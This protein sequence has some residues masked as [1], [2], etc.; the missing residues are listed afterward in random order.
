MSFYS[1]QEEIEANNKTNNMQMY[2][3]QNNDDSNNLFTNNNNNDG[4]Y[5]NEE[6]IKQEEFDNNN[7]K[8]KGGGKGDEFSTNY[9]VII[10]SFEH[11]NLSE[12]L[13]RGIFSYGWE[14]PSGIQQRAIRPMIEGRDIIA[15]AQSGTGKTGT[16]SISSLQRID[17][18]NQQCQ[19]LILSPTREIANQTF[20]VAS[21]LGIYLIDKHGLTIH[22]CIGGTSIRDDIY[23]LSSGKQIIIGTPGRV[24][25]VI[26][27]GVLN[28]KSLSL[29]ILDEADEMLSRGFKEQIY[30]C[31]QYLP[32]DVQVSLVSATMPI[33]VLKLTKRFM[34]NNAVQILVK[35][36]ELTLDG[37]K[38]YYVDTEKE[39][40][41]LATLF[42]LY[43]SLTIT[44]AIIF[45]NTR[46]KVMWLR[47]KMSQNDFTVS[48][49]HGDLTQSDRELVMKE[50]RSGTSRVLISTD[51]LSRGI[52]VQTVSLVINYDLPR[53][54]ESYIH[55]IGR[56][57]RY[58]RKGCAINFVY[59]D[60]SEKLR[61]LETFYNTIISELPAEL[62]GITN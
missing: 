58:G 23:Q 16:F 10:E 5:Q 2:D 48:F 35:N 7:K 56:S 50:F 25:H 42:D 38:Q 45:V 21:S 47:D 34:R 4:H 62:N 49:I 51:I 19:V 61:E 28:L 27:K 59:N 11:M 3:H 44:Q 18:N 26:Q 13:L 33:E 30:E 8:G 31:F 43:Q 60:D 55:R 53:F 29:F 20:E 57:G 6:E 22:K 40:F 52:D 9:D 36:K 15:Q 37:I 41:K 32:Q 39:E 14:K 54:K 24:N 17:L 1:K 46:R 12:D